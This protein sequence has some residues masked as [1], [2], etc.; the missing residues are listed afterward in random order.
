MT[1]GFG[2]VHGVAMEKV[3]SIRPLAQEGIP[4]LIEDPVEALQV[5]EE[6]LRRGAAFYPKTNDSPLAVSAGKIKLD[7]CDGDTAFT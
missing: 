1:A 5:F 3:V 4:P 6:I 2:N 7:Y